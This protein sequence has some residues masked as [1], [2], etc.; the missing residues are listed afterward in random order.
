MNRRERRKLLDRRKLGRKSMDSPV[1][2]EKT[3]GRF[4][5]EVHEQLDGLLGKDT[6]KEV[7]RFRSI[8]VENY[9]TGDI[10]TFVFLIH[11]D[12]LLTINVLTPKDSPEDILCRM[13]EVV[14]SYID[15]ENFHYEGYREVCDFIEEFISHPIVGY[16]VEDGVPT[17]DSMFPFVKTDSGGV[18]LHEC[19]M[20]DGKQKEGVNERIN[21]ED[22][23]KV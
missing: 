23:R 4:R 14:Q 12:D 17:F 20:S 15:G 3:E 5:E 2:V 7:L 21:E 6:D 13:G 18:T 16:Q 9:Q 8:D 11:R 22:L 1:L 19:F 10:N